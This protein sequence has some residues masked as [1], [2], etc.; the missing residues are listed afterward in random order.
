MID[1]QLKE[2][3]EHINPSW[4][5]LKQSSLWTQVPKQYEL[6]DLFLDLLPAISQLS[7]E[8]KYY[9]MWSLDTVFLDKTGRAHLVPNLE[10]PLEK[11]AE[12]VAHFP[13]F[14]AFEQHTD[15]SMWPL[16]EHTDVYGL[17]ALM[18]TLITKQ[19]PTPAPQ[20]FVLEDAPLAQM[21]LTAYTRQF[22]RAL[23]LAY[24]VD[25]NMRLKSL[26]EWGQ[27]AGLISTSH[28]PTMAAETTSSSLVAGSA[29]VVPI[30]ETVIDAE[31][32][33][34]AARKAELLKEAAL[35]K[36]AQAARE[37]QAAKEAQAAREA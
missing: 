14:S 9:G 24:Q 8:Q 31:Q 32:A 18:R 5:S 28:S 17:A 34:L 29:V 1:L 22:L 30:A 15:D 6:E 4:T 27:M 21:G 25:A 26:Q 10:Q 16:G 20:R 11:S 33:A 13:G 12:Q 2:K 35:I 37:T 3:L 23:D 7:M 36:E 19:A